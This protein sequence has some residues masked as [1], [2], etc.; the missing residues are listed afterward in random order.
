MPDEKIYP[1]APALSEPLRYGLAAAAFVV[2]VV[3]QPINVACLVVGAVF[4]F[5]G[6]LLLFVR[7]VATRPE[8]VSE[9]DWQPVTD[10]TFE[11]VLVQT[12]KNRKWQKNALNPLGGP[13]GCIVFIAFLAAAF[14]A[15]VMLG[16]SYFAS[17]NFERVADAD[18]NHVQLMWLV[19]SILFLIFYAASGIRFGY[20][21]E[22]LEFK[23]KTLFQSRDI[24][25]RYLIPKS[26]I[27]PGMK[28][29]KTKK[30]LTPV[31]VRLQIKID[32]RKDFYGVQVQANV[33][34]IP[35]GPNA[36]MHPYVYAVLVGQHDCGL[37]GV[38]EALGKP[39]PD[40]CVVEP[41]RKSDAEVIVIRQFTTSKSGYHTGPAAVETILSFAM[42][43]TETFLVKT[44]ERK[45]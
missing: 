1:I 3:L 28:Y 43:L 32:G 5:A 13:L 14:F 24:V 9:G 20:A 35:K 2:G 40:G 23:I 11:Q 19:D 27:V 39:V 10:E 38:Y 31:D 8:I 17:S 29:A 42:T 34:N 26:K 6:F 18:L 36:G 16:D 4:V 33:N 30:G 7:K 41:Q 12:A 22:E 37:V 15:L 45:A 21:P 25:K 44:A